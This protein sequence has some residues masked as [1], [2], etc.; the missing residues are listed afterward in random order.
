MSGSIP[1]A[2]FMSVFAIVQPASGDN[3]ASDE[4][5]FRVVNVLDFGRR[6][7]RTFCF[8][9]ANRHLFVSHTDKKDD[10]LYEW[11][12]DDGKIVNTYRLGDGFM[13]DNVSA[14]VDGRF[15]L[16][17]CYP[18]PLVEPAG[19]KRSDFKTILIDVKAGKS[20]R[21]FPIT[22][23][24]RSACFDKTST[25]ILVTLNNGQATVYDLDGHVVR[26][27]EIEGFALSRDKRV[28][29]IESS[30][31]TLQTHGLYLKDNKGTEHRL[32]DDV[33]GDNF[34]MTKDGRFIA[35]TTWKGQLIVWRCSDGGEVFHKTMAKQSG[36]Y[37]A[38]DGEKDR[39]LI[40]D[41][42]YNGTTFLRALELR[43]AK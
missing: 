38:Y 7:V 15:L 11:S 41:E 12:L 31:V 2:L 40:G 29:V 3:N 37:L 24:I 20:I 33:W 14:S 30:K 21:E 27:F 9:P 1:L 5:S 28:W 8:C 18:F 13:C 22:G 36:G 43:A 23:R 6:E 42:S 17:G 35:A 16:V 4:A 26:N 34:R 25:R 39:F 19:V 10:L 32:T